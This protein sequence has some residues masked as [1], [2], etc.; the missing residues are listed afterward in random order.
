V[1]VAQ[2]YERAA[3][4]Y[5]QAAAKGNTNAQ[6]NLGGLYY[7]GQGVPQSYERAAGLYT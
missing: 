6:F 1:S 3:E 5:K 4:F 2:S 7:D